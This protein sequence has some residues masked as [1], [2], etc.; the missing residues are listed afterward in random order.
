MISGILISLLLLGQAQEDELELGNLLDALTAE[1]A[2]EVGFTELR[3]SELLVDDLEISG[4][5]RH[6][7]QGR[8]IREIHAPEAETQIL[9]AS[10]VEIHRGDGRQR[11]FRLQRAPELEVLYHAL[12]G[13]LA[14]DAAALSKHFDTTVQGE[15]SAWHLVLRPRADQLA[16]SV[17]RLT[18]C[19]S[20]ARIRQFSLHLADGE[21][22]RTRLH[23]AP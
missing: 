23:A 14:G 22:V 16:E 4:T 17:E 18:V 21:I 20:D 12:N 3:Q 8:L 13:I 9:S 15:W 19:G 7:E 10:H 2:A 5:L 1:P 11:R 6:D